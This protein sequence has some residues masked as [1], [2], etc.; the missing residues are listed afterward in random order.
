MCTSQMLRAVGLV[1][2]AYAKYLRAFLRRYLSC[3]NSVLLAKVL[4]AAS[5]AARI[6]RGLAT[7]EHPESPAKHSSVCALVLAWITSSPDAPDCFRR[8]MSACTSVWLPASSTSFALLRSEAS[9][10]VQSAASDLRV[11]R[12]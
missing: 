5:R 2:V 9:I 11:A 8:S 4:L 1:T 3:E 6:C 7:G 12:H 10:A